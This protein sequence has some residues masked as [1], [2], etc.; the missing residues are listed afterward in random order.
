M[1][2]LALGN[3]VVSLKTVFEMIKWRTRNLVKISYSI[4]H[5]TI[6]SIDWFSTYALLQVPSGLS[7]CA[8]WM[9]CALISAARPLGADKEAAAAQATTAAKTM[10]NFIFSSF[11]FFVCFVVVTEKTAGNELMPI[12][13]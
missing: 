8:T 7:S 2:A 1:T 13:W 12:N 6:V 5:F 3:S 9:T 10:K 11:G 4:L